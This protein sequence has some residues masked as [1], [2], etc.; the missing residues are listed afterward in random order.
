[1]RRAKLFKTWNKK[2]HEYEGIVHVHYIGEVGD[3]DGSYIA[4]AIEL[5]DGEMR[6]V[7]ADRLHFIEPAKEVEPMSTRLKVA[8]MIA[9]STQA[10]MRFAKFDEIATESLSFAD[11]L[12]EEA[13]K[14]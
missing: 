8:A 10:A 2:E 7:A 14:R 5:E 9:G 13:K 11:I 12:I 6:E 4:A 1:M 3:E